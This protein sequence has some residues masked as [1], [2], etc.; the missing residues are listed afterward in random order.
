[1]Q[2]ILKNIFHPRLIESEN[3]DPVDREGWLYLVF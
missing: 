3:I 1:M 2:F